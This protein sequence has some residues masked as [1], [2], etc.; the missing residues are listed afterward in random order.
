[1]SIRIEI[2]WTN[3]YLK[4]IRPYIEDPVLDLI[5]MCHWHVERARVEYYNK[6]ETYNIRYLG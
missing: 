6:S 5:I 2:A 4:I 3:S 1:M